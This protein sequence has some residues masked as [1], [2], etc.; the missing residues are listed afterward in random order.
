MK[1][2]IW[3]RLCAGALATVMTASIG[4]GTSIAAFAEALGNDGSAVINEAYAD[5]E[6][7]M[8]L[9]PSFNSIRCWSG[10]RNPTPMPA[11]IGPVLRWQTVW[12]VL[13]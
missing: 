10:L 8:P 13:W 1:I 12:A 6:S 3:K 7:L 5:R 9:G 2:R 4:A 11:T